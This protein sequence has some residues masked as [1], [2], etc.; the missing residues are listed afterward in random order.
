METFDDIPDF[1]DGESGV[2]EGGYT[3]F[4]FL[5]DRENDD[6]VLSWLNEEFSHLYR[7]SK[8]RLYT[9]RRIARRCLN[10]D[11]RNN[12]IIRHNRRDSEENTD[13]PTIRTNFF[14]DYIDQKVAYLSRTPIRPTFIPK[15]DNSQE[16]INQ[17]ETCSLVTKSRA[18][19]INV[20][21]LMAKQDRLM[22]KYG[23]GVVK[24]YWDDFAGPIN[25]KLLEKAREIGISEVDGSELSEWNAKAGDVC[26]K[27]ISP[28][29][30]YAERGKKSWDCVNF[31]FE[32][33]FVHISELRA[34]YPGLDIAK[35][36]L[37]WLEMTHEDCYN[38]EN[39]VAKFMFYH[40]PTKFLPNGE[41]IIFTHSTILERVNSKEGIK[42]HM[43]D[44]EL[45]YIFDED[46]KD[47]EHLWAFPFLIN[48][49][50]QNNFYDLIQSGIAR[51]VGVAQAPKLL[52][53]EG[54]V[55]FKQLNNKY[56]V[57]Q[58]NGEKPTWMQHNYVNRGEFEIQDRLE[59]RMDRHAKVGAI[60]K[61]DIPAGITAT[62]A[63][64]LLDDQE[65][66]A[67]T[68]ALRK[69]KDRVKAFYWKLMKFQEANYDE[70]SERLLA[71]LGEDNEYLIETFTKPR[72]DIIESVEIENV[73]ALSSN[74]A[75]RVSD[76]IDLNAANQKDPT[77]GRKEIIKL[78]DLG[79]EEAF[80]EETAYS[81]TTAKTL[82]EY[83][84]KGKKAVPANKTDDLFE[85]YGIFSRYVESISYKLKISEEARASINDYIM[86]IEYLI[87]DQAQKNPVFRAKLMEYPKFPMFFDG[88]ELVFMQGG[89]Q[90]PPTGKS[91]SSGA[92]LGNMNEKNMKEIERNATNGGIA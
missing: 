87:A 66:E 12:A 71:I 64:R 82:L 10:R 8:D 68:E 77:F 17:A 2:I 28:A 6:T 29:Y 54:S 88:G 72:Y 18:N 51:N 65:L 59:R 15:V 62:S 61:Q 85:M 11:P 34:E 55:N 48:I 56:G 1:E 76:I 78:L 40:K 60:S 35:E 27:E 4:Q 33:E 25:S 50:Q 53:Q 20:D 70:S 30:L 3:P 83:L 58:Y 67:N 24:L 86:G 75:G 46:I 57:L 89:E 9:Y 39:Y 19:Q 80:V 47:E 43:P 90:L 74:R 16:D 42:K 69:K 38:D 5:N 26:A 41:V 32:V 37:Y 31:I 92:G 13:K 7:T 22:F 36:D 23:T 84:K 49:E 73:S 79:L 21:A 81:V 91:S 44:G 63:L 14:L 52:I 45:P